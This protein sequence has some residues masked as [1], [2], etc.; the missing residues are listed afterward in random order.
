MDA[1]YTPTC[2]IAKHR[3]YLTIMYTLRI[4]GHQESLMHTFAKHKRQSHS[5]AAAT[6]T[7][8]QHTQHNSW[9]PSRW[10]P[11][12]SSTHSLECVE[13]GSATLRSA[14]G[15]RLVPRRCVCMCGTCRLNL[16]LTNTHPPLCKQYRNKECALKSPAWF[17]PGFPYKYGQSFS[18]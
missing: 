12:S 7:L 18:C 4:Y 11:G 3:S 17:P 5:E 1:L 9:V 13:E 6:H 8:K 14:M 10:L 2:A 16:H 15:I